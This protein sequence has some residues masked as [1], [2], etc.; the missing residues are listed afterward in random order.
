MLSA[1]ERWR[2]FREEPR[3]R[4]RA[5]A[6]AEVHAAWDAWLARK[7]AA[8]EAGEPFTEPTPSA[9]AAAMPD[10]RASRPRERP[11]PP[12]RPVGLSA[13]ERWRRFKEEPKR[14][15]AEITAEVDAAWEAW[16]GRREAARAAGEDFTEPRPF[17][18]PDVDA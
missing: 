3:E 7:R 10:P 15:R 11:V 8:D 5:E 18:S 1:A 9:V 12:H 13:A 4:L 6:R 16:L 14:I 2:R 17:S